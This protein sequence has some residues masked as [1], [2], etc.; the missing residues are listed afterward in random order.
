M[1]PRVRVTHEGQA[2][3]N[4]LLA[5]LDGAAEQD[6]GNVVL[7]AGS[8]EFLVQDQAVWVV[9]FQREAEVNSPHCH[10]Q[11]CWP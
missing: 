8:V 1:L 11:I 10:R 4:F 2:D 6:E 9:L 3:G 5:E 7:Q